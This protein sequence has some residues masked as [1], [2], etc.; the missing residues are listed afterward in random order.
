MLHVSHNGLGTAPVQQ[1]YYSLLSSIFRTL[2][3]RSIPIPTISH[4]HSAHAPLDFMA[5]AHYCSADWTFRPTPRHS[6]ILHIKLL[7]TVGFHLFPLMILCYLISN[8]LTWTGVIY[9]DEGKD[10]KERTTNEN[11]RRQRNA[12]HGEDRS[13]CIVAYVSKAAW[14]HMHRP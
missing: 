12:C 7:G 8:F 14:K 5:P 3:H 10:W 1:N 11:V 4:S 2:V 13:I 9:M 6:R